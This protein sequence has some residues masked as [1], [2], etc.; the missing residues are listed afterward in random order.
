M[1]PGTGAF[2]VEMRSD[3]EAVAQLFYDVGK[4]LN[5]GSSATQSVGGSD[6]YSTLRFRLPNDP[7]RALRFDPLNGPGNFSIRRAYVADRFGR[8]V[9]QFHPND[10]VP[11][12]QIAN[13][14]ESGSEVRF[15]TTA[16]AEIPCCRS[17]FTG[18]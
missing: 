10:L 13:R 17:G 6:T 4:G 15:S 5:E 8:V 1:Q 11:L 16:T 18:R 14:L 12:N 2:V 9:Q 3:A 7:I